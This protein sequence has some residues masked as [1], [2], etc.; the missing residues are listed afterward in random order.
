MVCNIVGVDLCNN[1]VVS[2][3]SQT[4]EVYEVSA[5]SLQCTA[6]FTLQ[7]P[8]V[9]VHDDSIFRVNINNLEACNMA[10]TVKQTLVLDEVMA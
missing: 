9:A 2:W 8:A 10:G 7:T 5:M 3:S 6:S 4:A 1:N